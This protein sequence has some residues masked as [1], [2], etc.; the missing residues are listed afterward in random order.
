MLLALLSILSSAQAGPGPSLAAAPLVST[1]TLIAEAPGV[2][3]YQQPWTDG[4]PDYVLVV[5]LTQ[6]TVSSVLDPSGSELN[7]HTIPGFWD[8]AS[9]AEGRFAMVNGAFFSTASDP[10]SPAFGLRADPYGYV[11]AGYGTTSEYVG[12]QRSLHIRNS[13]SRAAI[14]DAD[15]ASLDNP[16]SAPEQV[17][18]LH[19]EADKS[20]SSWVQRTF[21]GVK[22]PH[23][24]GYR[25]LLFFVSELATQE[26]AE[27]ELI[28][29]G[30]VTTMMLD[31]GGS[32]QLRVDGT[33]WVS[34]SREVPQAFL[35]QAWHE[36]EEEP[37]PEP[38][39]DPDPDPDP[40]EP[41]EPDPDPDPDSGE[42]LA[43]SRHEA[44]GEGGCGG[45]GAWGMLL[46]LL[47]L[48]RLPTRGRP[49][50]RA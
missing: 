16:E 30:A 24:G 45:K 20:A 1:Y 35:I 18:A 10:T 33:D 13:A 23:E 32:S 29:W 41:D 17:V 36:P 5:D 27:D 44:E 21:A 19:P 15:A 50:P 12:Q 49:C 8:R 4:A 34:S 37:E 46:P 48:L 3:L 14:V 43:G 38:E 42:E 28:A 47:L 6:A 2:Q 40:E 26:F 9:A 22:D 25:T 11:H 31:G 39:P 7:R